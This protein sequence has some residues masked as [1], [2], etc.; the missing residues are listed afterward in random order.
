VLTALLAAG[1]TPVVSPVSL[2]AGVR[3]PE[4]PL[5]LNINGDTV[6]GDIAAAVEAKK[7]VFLTDVDGLRGAD[8]HTISRL[9]PAEAQGLLDS[10]VATGGMIPKLK[11]CLVAAAAGVSCHIVDGRKPHA[12]A[13]AVAGATSGTVVAGK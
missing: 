10:G 4:E 1:F 13:E 7:L 12:L 2:H 9:T 11:A 5:L 3:K 6:A 8:G